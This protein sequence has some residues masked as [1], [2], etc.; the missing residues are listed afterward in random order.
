MSCCRARCAV[1]VGD[2]VGGGEPGQERDGASCGVRGGVEKNGR[3]GVKRED[4]SE[5]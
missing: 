5:G 4:A 1:K 2:G 3:V